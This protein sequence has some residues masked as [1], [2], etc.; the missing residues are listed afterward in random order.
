[1]YPRLCGAFIATMLLCLP[2]SIAFG[3]VAS[4]EPINIVT[5]TVPTHWAA[6]NAFESSDGVV[7]TDDVRCSKIG[8]GERLY[9]SHQH[10]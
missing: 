5:A 7:A 10:Y 9:S 6:M 1:L 4:D 8:A 2:I 3:V